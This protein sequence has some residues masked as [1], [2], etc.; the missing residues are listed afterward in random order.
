MNFTW[1]LSPSSQSRSNSGRNGWIRPELAAAAELTE[2]A[3]TLRI[4]SIN[5]AASGGAE[6]TRLELDGV[7][8][9][10]DVVNPL[11]PQMADTVDP[12]RVTG[13]S[14]TVSRLIAPLE[15]G[16]TYLVSYSIIEATDD[17][18]I[19]TGPN[20]GGAFAAESLPTSPGV[21]NL[22]LRVTNPEGTRVFRMRGD[23]TFGYLSCRKAEWHYTLPQGIAHPE[24]AV[25]ERPGPITGTDQIVSALNAPLE[26]GVAYILR[27]HVTAANGAVSL[28]TQADAGSPFAT[29][30]LPHSVGHHAVTLTAESDATA[31]IARATGDLSISYFSCRRA[32]GTA[33]RQIRA[34]I[35]TGNV[36]AETVL[37]TP[38]PGALHVAPDGDDLEGTGA[39]AAPFRTPAY[40]AS[41]A[42][43]G[44]TIY[45]R[46]GTYG[47]FEV[48]NSGM[49]GKPITFT[50]LPGEEHQAII[51]GDLSQHVFYGGPGVEQSNSMRDGIFMAGKSHIHIRNLWVRDFWRAGI[52]CRGVLGSVTRGIVIAHN[53]TNRTGSSGI[54]VT[55]LSSSQDG[56]W[57]PTQ[58][59][60][61]PLDDVL[62]EY[63]DVSDTNT[64]TDWNNTSGTAQGVP[65]GVSEC[66]TVV[67]GVS[68]VITRYNDVHDS[69][70]YGIDYKAGVSG[71]AIHGNRVWNIVRY[72]LY[73]DTGRAF[74]EDIDV[75]DNM[76]WNCRMG[77]VMAREPSLHVTAWVQSFR[78]INVY[79][80]RFWNIERAGIFLQKHPFD[81][82][83][84]PPL[85]ELPSGYTY[86]PGVSE[87][88]PVGEISNVRVRFNTIYNA[89]RELGRNDLNMHGWADAEFLSEGIVSSV[90]FVGNIVWNDTDDASS[91][92]DF[93]GGQPQFAYEDN[94]FGV[95]P[96]FVDTSNA[97]FGGPRPTEHPDLSYPEISYIGQTIP[98]PDLRLQPGS[99]AIGLMDSARAAAPF[100]L[101]ADS[102]DRTTQPAAGAWHR[103]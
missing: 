68:N 67:N 89:A 82:A 38:D 94:L 13:N 78:N 23:I 28:S 2:G 42:Q 93:F 102:K 79:N 12:G 17:S 69:R 97:G 47:P 88:D 61:L 14:A 21:H 56:F 86:P 54:F 26:P 29:T 90:D 91:S 41:V 63:N 37:Y 92:Q 27:Y 87:G 36:A 75:Y 99:P 49:E 55:G 31:A 34:V 66:I 71:G 25:T 62:I 50:T 74:V 64:I 40:A 52:Y 100:D 4:A 16:A 51:E 70:Q 3:L 46:P 15:E 58:T 19:W 103:T 48:L 65:G 72:G 11:S 59:T 101:D 10:G 9:L 1:G 22:L 95:D 57:P 44:N 32:G 30:A 60:E 7:S 53:R 20:G 98:M 84:V 6:L 45:I 5:S 80:N 77:F 24:R 43:P 35:R 39:R 81:H 83:V 8:V 18:D 76:V 96:L 73:L 33:G 85:S